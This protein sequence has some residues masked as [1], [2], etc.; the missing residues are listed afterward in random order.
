VAKLAASLPHTGGWYVYLRE[1]LGRLASFLIGWS[2]LVLIR[3]SAAGAISTMFSEYFLQSMGHDPAIHGAAADYVAAGAIVLAATINIRGVQLGAMIAGAS[4]VA[5]FGALAFLVIASFV[6]GG[7]AGASTTNFTAASAPVDAGLFGLV[8]ISVLWAYDGFAD[9]SFAADEANDPQRNLPRAII[10]GTLVIIGIYLAANAAYLHVNPVERLATS[11]LIA[12]DSM[13]AIFGPIGVAFVSVVVTISTFGALIAIM[14]SAPRV[15]FA[16]ADD[17]LVFR[18]MARVHPRYE[19]PYVA[20][21]LA[22]AL[23]VLFVLT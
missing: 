22:A 19:T 1:G 9:L 20:I 23:G 15:F 17:R 3:A 13:Q 6:L 14:L 18:A 2:E 4:S 7:G 10:V 11:P 16:M 8:L 5:K 21:A 12:A